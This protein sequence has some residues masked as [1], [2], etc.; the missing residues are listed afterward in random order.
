MLAA[1]QWHAS[2]FLPFII[3]LAALVVL[4]LPF[5]KTM[6]AA[7][8]TN[9]DYSHGYFIP[10]ISLYMIWSV[11]GE[12]ANL[13][14]RPSNA[15]MLVVLGGLGLLLIA[16]IGSELF[17]QRISLI[18]VLLGLVLF[19]LGRDYF[20][21][22]KWPILYLI[23]MIPLPAIIWNKIAFPL[24]LFGS[25]LTEQIVRLIGIPIFRQGNVLHLAE[26]TLEVVAA[27]SGLRSLLTMFAL[28][29][30]LIWMSSLSVGRRWVLFL[31]AAPAALIAN[32]VRLTTT[33]I[34]ASL[35]GSEVAQGFLHDFSGLLT[36]IIGLSLLLLIARSLSR[37]QSSREN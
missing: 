4:Y 31:S 12:L 36:F 17:L 27:C 7:W 29:S 21:L 23:F 28:S 22:L 11:R 9:E 37:R 16:K 33:A 24:Q 6:V 15:G 34:L 2:T 25:Y 35:Y 3:A 30:L 19:L 1:R 20:K 18:I 10:F 14:I 26:T 5:L 8:A 32:I 13:K